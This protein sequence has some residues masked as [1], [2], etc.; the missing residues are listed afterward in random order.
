LSERPSSSRDGSDAVAA[1]ELRL[2]DEASV[3]ELL[4]AAFGAWPRGLD[5]GRPEELFSWKHRAS[6]FGASTLLVADVDGRVAGFLA[7]MPWRLRFGGVVQE[8]MRGVDLA[9]DP[10]AR[11]RG[12][13]MS[14]IGAARG[15]YGPEIALGWS[16]PNESSRLGVLKSGRRRVAGLPMFV[17]PGSP[18]RGGGERGAAQARPDAPADR[19]H[20]AGNLLGD[21]ALLARALEHASERDG[22]IATAHTAAFLRWRYGALGVYQAVAAQRGDHCG[23]AIYRVQRRRRMRVARI[24]ELL[25]D[26]DATLARELTRSVRRAARASVLTCA[27][28]DART[29]ADC[30]FVRAP[31]TAMIATNPLHAELAPDPTLPRSWALS[32]GDLELV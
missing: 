11:R 6:P 17:A 27:F 23:I 18:A 3:L 7:L 26:G 9:V 13:S 22:R 24:C 16:N 14:L 28:P 15:H 19:P 1:R 30:G 12:V 32:L 5:G 4:K 31:R 8:T 29:A 21:E 20:D 2:E 10:G 25:F